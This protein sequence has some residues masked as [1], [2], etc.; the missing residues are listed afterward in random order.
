MAKPSITLR[1]TTA[2]SPLTY[3]QLDQNFTNLQ[4]ATISLD[5]GTG[6]TTVTS[7]LNGKITLVAGSNVTLTGDNTAKTVTISA[8]GGTGLTNP[9]TADLNTNNYEIFNGNGTYVK[10]TDPVEIGDGVDPA[11]IHTLGATG[12]YI[13]AGLS[14]QGKGIYITSTSIFLGETGGTT[15]TTLLGQKAVCQSTFQLNSYTTTERNSITA[16]EGMTIYNSTLDA[17][18]GY[19]NGA[20]VNL[21]ASNGPAFSAYANNTLQTITS[22]SQQKV[23]FQT[24]EFDTN[25]NYA[26]SRFTPTVA[27]YYQL[28]SSV[29][30]DGSTGTGEIMIVIWKNGSEY[31]RGTNQQGTQIATDFWEMNVSSLVYAN[32]S[33]DYFEIYVQQTSGSSRTVTAVASPNI[34]YF[35]GCMIRPA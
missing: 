20:W 2:P 35:N 24:E 13:S 22:G 15:G 18:Q 8:T 4:N 10:I 5:A 23:L 19:A 1:S 3:A 27:G 31:K 29:R 32:G 33:S 9:L 7:D 25:N 14:N 26:S 16:S 6:G 30:I 21:S 17:F 12:L 28:N 34:T 11:Q